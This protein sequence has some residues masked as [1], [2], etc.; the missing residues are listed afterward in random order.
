MNQTLSPE[1]QLSIGIAIA[2]ADSRL[3][4]RNVAPAGFL[5]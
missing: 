4:A 2:I 1:M 5:A 3:P